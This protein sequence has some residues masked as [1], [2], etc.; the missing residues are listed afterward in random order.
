MNLVWEDLDCLYISLDDLFMVNLIDFG[1]TCRLFVTSQP[2]NKKYGCA[3]SHILKNMDRSPTMVSLHF[4]T[5]LSINS[6]R[7]LLKI[8]ITIDSF[9]RLDSIV[10]TLFSISVSS[11]PLSSS[12]MWG[13]MI[14]S[15]WKS[16]IHAYLLEYFKM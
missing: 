15:H 7:G 11:N 13:R 8:L 12:R 14:I 4:Q 10:I 16:L 6:W 5:A 2:T 1:K 3:L 9:H